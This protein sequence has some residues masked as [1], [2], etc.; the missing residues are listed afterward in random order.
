ME[1]YDRHVLKVKGIYLNFLIWFVNK[2]N[3]LTFF[4]SSI[5]IYQHLASIINRRNH[6]RDRILANYEYCWSISTLGKER[7]LYDCGTNDIKH[8]KRNDILDAISHKTSHK[9]VI[10]CRTQKKMNHRDIKDAAVKINLRQTH[11]LL[12]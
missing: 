3:W 5:L 7:S 2:I 1:I 12:F 6:M 9:P 4:F 11:R 10:S 8:V